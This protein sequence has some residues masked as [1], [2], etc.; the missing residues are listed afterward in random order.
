MNRY[1]VTVYDETIHVHADIIEYENVSDE[2][3]R[4][5]YDKLYDRTLAMLNS[6][7]FIVV[8][9]SPDDAIQLAF[10]LDGGISNNEEIIIRDETD[11]LQLAK[12]YSEII[13]VEVHW[14]ITNT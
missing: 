2:I 13:A 8:A 12:M 7:T 11:L 3:T 10:A 5:D 4:E 6:K 14:C 9:S 1:V